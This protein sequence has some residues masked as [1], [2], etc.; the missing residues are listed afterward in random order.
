MVGSGTSCGGG[1][2]ALSKI[3]PFEF[4]VYIYVYLWGREISNMFKRRPRFRQPEA[5]R[6]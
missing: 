3:A 1:G 2:G 5:N 4:L 6:A